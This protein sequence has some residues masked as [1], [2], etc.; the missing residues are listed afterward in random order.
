MTVKQ[1]LQKHLI[2]SLNMKNLECPYEPD[3]S[4]LESYILNEIRGYIANSYFSD[5]AV[6]E[7]IVWLF[8]K[9]KIDYNGRHE[10]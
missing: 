9:Y 5:F 6:I 8:D 3:V 2:E 7:K 1:E 10:I 4:W